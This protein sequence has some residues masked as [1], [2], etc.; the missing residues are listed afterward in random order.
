MKT[1][2][3][4]GFKNS[5]KT[6][7]LE[8]WIAL[9]K[10]SGRSVAVLKHHGHGG[11]LDMPGDGT[12][13]ERFFRQG[14]DV[15]LAAGGGTSQVLL[16]SEPDFEILKQLASFGR[17]DVLLI[18]G[19]KNE[20]GEKVVLVRGPDDWETLRQLEDI[21]LIVGDVPGASAEVIGSRSETGRLDSWFADWLEKEELDETV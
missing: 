17:P 18:E 15:S 19:Y 16:N 20:P 7:L 11:P 14:A 10:A 8:R 1:L 2:H 12:D 5:G 6:T 21:R 4:V 13:S 9:A 3:I